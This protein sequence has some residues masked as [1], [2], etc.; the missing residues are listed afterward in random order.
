MN[1]NEMLAAFDCRDGHLYR[2]KAAGGQK[3]GSCVGWITE[4]NGKPYRKMTFK[5]KTEYVH[6]AIFLML[7]GYLPDVIDHKNR[8]TLDNHIDNLRAATQVQNMGNTG[9]S[10]ANTSGRKGVTRRKDTG[11]WAAQIMFKGKHISLG[12]YECIEDAAQAYE[13][14]SRKYF[15]EFAQ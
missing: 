5:G 7:N 12:S 9:L 10:A 3:V 11:K 2:R 14:A 1:Q 13:H 8:N 15:G 6:R 4:C